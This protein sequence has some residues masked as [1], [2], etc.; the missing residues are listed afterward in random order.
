MNHRPGDVEQLS[1]TPS[2]TRRGFC[3][4]NMSVPDDIQSYGNRK[5]ARISNLCSQISCFLR[6]SAFAPAPHAVSHV[7]S[8]PTARFQWEE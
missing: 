4:E 6:A 3:P 8:P 2:I 5:R 1:V 7:E